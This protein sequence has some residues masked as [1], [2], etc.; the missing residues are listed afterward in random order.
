MNSNTIRCC[1]FLI[2]DHWIYFIGSCC[3]ST[4]TNHT[5]TSISS[6]TSSSCCVTFVRIFFLG[7]KFLSILWWELFIFLGRH[8]YHASPVI[9]T[10]AVHHTPVVAV[11][12]S[13]V[14]A[15]H[16]SPIY[17]TPVYH[18]KTYVAAPVYHKTVV[19]VV[20]HGHSVLI[21]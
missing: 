17:H 16:S 21:H 10:V 3:S 18:H 2:L 12:H 5:H 20:H 7:F 1:C 15:I 4:S 11:R 8:V 19:P 9:K 6:F 13:P 14:V